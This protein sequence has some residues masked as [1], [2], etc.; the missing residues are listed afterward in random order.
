MKKR[1]LITHIRLAQFDL[2][3]EVEDPDVLAREKNLTSTV[4]FL[5][6]VQDRLFPKQAE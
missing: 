5:I 3:Y 6:C 1:D 4:G 2:G